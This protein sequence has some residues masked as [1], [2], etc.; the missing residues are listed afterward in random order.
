MGKK[1]AANHVN[2]YINRNVSPQYYAESNNLMNEIIQLSS[3]RG[4]SSNAMQRSQYGEK[5][6]E[7][8]YSKSQLSRSHLN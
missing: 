4:H 6:S 1:S 7:S 5:R 3:S 2:P 8:N